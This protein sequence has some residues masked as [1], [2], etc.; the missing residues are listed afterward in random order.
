MSTLL[1]VLLV[2]IVEIAIIGGLIYFFWV[3]FGKIWFNSL[4]NLNKIQNL[5]KNDFKIPNLS[6][7]HKEMEKL[8][9][10]LKKNHKK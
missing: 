7:F 4:N 10:H 2:L 1:I 5:T 6:K 9:E 8:Q 3:K